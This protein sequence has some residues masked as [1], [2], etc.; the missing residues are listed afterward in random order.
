MMTSFLE[1]QYKRIDIKD[2]KERFTR[3]LD[4]FSN[5]STLEEQKQIILNI[6]LLRNEVDT[7]INLAQIR[8]TLDTNDSFYKIEQDYIDRIEPDVQKMTSEYYKKMIETPFRNEL[9]KEW[10]E[11]LFNLAETQI[12]TFSKEIIPLLQKENELVS[13]YTKLVASAKIPFKGNILT[14]NQLRPYSESVD[15]KTRK[16]ASEAIS[17]FFVVHQQQ[18]EQ[19]YHQLVQIRTE[20]A[21]KLGYKNFVELGYHRLGRTDY[22]AEMVAE[23]RRQVKEYI[24][25]FSEKL[26]DR[27]KER[28]EV[29]Q[30]Y[31]FDEPIKFLSGNATPK[32]DADWII[33]QGQRMYEE[34]SKETRDF[35]QFM[36]NHQLMDLIAK[37]GKA[38]GGYCSYIAGYKSPFVFSNFSGVS[39]DVYVFIHEAGH[40]FQMYS[41]RDY[42]FP[43]YIFPTIEACEIHSMSM[44]FFTWP[45]MELFFKEDTEKYKFAHLSEAILSIPYRTAVDEFQHFV[46]EHPLITPAER[47][48][49]WRKIEKEYLPKRNYFDNDYLE[50]GGFWQR[51]SH[52]FHSPF[53]YIDY[54]L[55]QICALQFWKKINHNKEEAW[56]DYLHLCKLGG[57]QSFLGLIKEAKLISPFEK[58][59]IE[60]VIGEVRT[61]LDSINDQH[62]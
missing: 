21:Y 4:R 61:W 23:F 22:N 26:L 57:T 7:M 14:L 55:A 27:Q 29:D 62:L 52:L 51:Q 31:Y 37:E 24:V 10:G 60:S 13:D 25:P 35:F 18:F 6:N 54:N 49:A 17:T 28:I 46:Y 1:Y 32:G 34:L 19:I 16:Q 30:L 3:E 2:W 42:G 59:C 36:I 58:G 11:Q 48:A 41:S 45:W 50:S 5:Q 20:I 9:E 40:A 43:E 38:T 33:Q 44:E 47:N 12:N 56:K 8:H 53:Y 15:R 39:S